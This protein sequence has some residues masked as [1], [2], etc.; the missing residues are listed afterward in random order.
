M[1]QAH[2]I[3]VRELEIALC[4]VEIDGSQVDAARSTS[5]RLQSDHD[6]GVAGAAALGQ[7][8]TDLRKKVEAAAVLAVDLGESEH[9]QGLYARLARDLRTDGFQDFLLQEVFKGL[10]RGAS[11]RL[12]DLS[13]RYTFD[14]HEGAF[15]VLD[16]DN[17]RERRIADTLSGGE[18][19]LAS[20]ALALELSEQVQ[21]S[22]GAVLLDSI[23]IDEGFGTLDPET[24]ETV[25]GAVEAL[26][27]G[28]RMV[29][30]ISHVEELTERL[31]KLVVRR[32]AGGSRVEGPVE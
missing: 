15:H 28:G 32:E 29:G 1:R 13:G 25:A 22:A 31:P 14:Y 21:R 7:R 23:F 16:H 10:V 17:A 6:D 12:W 4:G 20:L 11:T 18:T 5:R 27:V 24:L 8:L 26:P 3:R 9:R 19:F 30:I 2:E